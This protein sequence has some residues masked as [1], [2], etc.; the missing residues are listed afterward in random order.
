MAEQQGKP[1]FVLQKMELQRELHLSGH[2][3]T[4]D[5][6]KDTG[7]ELLML[8]NTSNI[9]RLSDSNTFGCHHKPVLTVA[10]TFQA[11]CQ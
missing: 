11:V 7:Y 6:W 8:S 5:T 1:N 2:K 9:L 10:Q 3:H 4:K